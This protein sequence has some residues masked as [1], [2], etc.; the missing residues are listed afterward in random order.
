MNS[1]LKQLV[2]GYS[3]E[4]TP[5][6]ATKIPDYRY[7]L[8]LGTTVYV[9]LL[10][11]STIDD[12]LSICERLVSEGFNPVPHYAARQI[13]NRKKLE[14]SLKRFRDDSGG[15]QVLALAGTSATPVGDY[16][17]SMQLLDTGLFDKMGI[18]RIGVA[19]HPEGSP[20]ISK[21]QLAHAIE[22]KNTFAERTDADMHIV[23]QFCFEASPV[24]EWE[25]QL[26]ESG[27]ALPIHIGVPGVAT[28]GTL[29][30]HAAACGIGASAQ[31]L[32][33]QARNATKLLMNST[34]ERLLRDLANHR[35]ENP[36]SII[37][38]LHVYPLGGLRKSAEWFDNIQSEADSGKVNVA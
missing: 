33:K 13:P 19:G 5:G 36:D 31:F 11:G 28:I 7:I 27:N 38:T 25:R 9:T 14:D 34:P 6:S 4:T 22:W 21:A 35:I 30:K 24:I 17:N 10:P 12:T 37:E 8:S 23:T 32:K 3:V 2:H 1:A 15:T 26:V 29:I 16:E 18:Q 20:D